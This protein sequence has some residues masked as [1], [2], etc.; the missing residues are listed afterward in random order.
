MGSKPIKTPLY[1]NLLTYKDI[2][3]KV[4]WAPPFPL[5][6]NK[7]RGRGSVRRHK[8]TVGIVAGTSEGH[9]Q[10][11]TREMVHTLSFISF[12]HCMEVV[13]LLYK[14]GTEK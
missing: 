4:P 14:G 12:N 13:S 3:G 9:K 8:H 7:F 11:I 5:S 10:V 2:R 1:N 6:F